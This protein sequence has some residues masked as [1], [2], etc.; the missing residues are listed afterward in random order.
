MFVTSDAICLRD[1]NKLMLCPQKWRQILVCL[2]DCVDCYS[3]INAYVLVAQCSSDEVNNAAALVT[4][5][6]SC[7]T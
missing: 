4:V 7:L 6:H 1:R 2:S 3:N 5:S